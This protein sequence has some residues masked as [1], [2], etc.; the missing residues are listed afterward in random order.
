M[1]AT[2]VVILIEN[3][4]TIYVQGLHRL[5][6]MLELYSWEVSQGWNT[7]QTWGVAA[8]WGYVYTYN[9]RKSES[10]VQMKSAIGCEWEQLW[11]ESIMWPD[12]KSNICSGISLEPA[13]PAEQSRL[14]FANTVLNK[15]QICLH[16]VHVS[17]LDNDVMATCFT[18]HNLFNPSIETTCSLL[19]RENNKY[20]CV[21]QVH[22][23]YLLFWL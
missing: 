6:P 22:L 21:Y 9:R 19:L 14:Q 23:K 2:I 13:F 11:S 5:R 18:F 4:K 10:A 12:C 3:K 16:V 17:V 20:A 15:L 1:E 8:F 7:W